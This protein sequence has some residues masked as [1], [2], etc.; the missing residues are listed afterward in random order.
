[1]IQIT[2]G[3]KLIFT[4][5]SVQVEVEQ[6]EDTVNF[7]VRSNEVSPDKWRTVF[8]DS[9]TMDEVAQLNQGITS[10]IQKVTR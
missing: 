3:T 9:M 6:M 5:Q 8:S 4:G 7:Y 10:F 2:S 1:M